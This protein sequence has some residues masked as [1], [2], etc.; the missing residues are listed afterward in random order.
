MLKNGLPPIRLQ[1]PDDVSPNT[2]KLVEY[3]NN[4]I[5]SASDCAWHPIRL[6]RFGRCS[7]LL[8]ERVVTVGWRPVDY[9]AM[10][11]S[12]RCESA[13]NWMGADSHA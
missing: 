3:K 11:E 13:P 2:A 4:H 10:C 7:L 8:R 9:G 12:S 1:A 5:A 6:A